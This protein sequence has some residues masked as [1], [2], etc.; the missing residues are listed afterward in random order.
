MAAG[1]AIL[2]TATSTYA[3][4][5][6]ATPAY[7]STTSLAA[8]N[9]FQ[10]FKR[11]IEAGLGAALGVAVLTAVVFAKMWKERANRATELANRVTE[12]ERLKEPVMPR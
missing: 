4:A 8:L 3:N 5:I 1:L 7:N 12:L 10:S 2:L 9:N 6:T 11:G